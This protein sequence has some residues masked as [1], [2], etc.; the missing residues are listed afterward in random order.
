MTTQADLF[1]EHGNTLK[2]D[3]HTGIPAKVT[4]YDPTTNTLACEVAVREPL[5][6]ADGDREYMSY[7][8]LVNVPVQWPRFG[9]K[10]VRGML[11]PGDWVWLAFSEASLAEWRGSGQTSEPV[12]ARRLSMGYPFATPGAFPDTEPLNADDALEVAAGA[13]LIGEDGG[14]QI[15]I[16]GLLPGIRFGKT[17]I[18]PIA[19]A[20]PITTAL[21]AIQAALAAI[22]LVPT[23]SAVPATGTA[24]AASATAVTTAASTGASTL[25]K[26]E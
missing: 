17:A 22:G 5:F 8:S 4:L 10:V 14:D 3:I 1:R 25:V 11:E 20:T 18:V 7:P 15:L 9:G 21:T 19:L 23:V 12:D 24:I 16:G 2:A 13:L 26:S 6:L